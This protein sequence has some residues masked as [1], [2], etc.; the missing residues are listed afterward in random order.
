MTNKEEQ[1]VSK[2]ASSEVFAFS[3][4]E[5]RLTVSQSPAGYA[6]TTYCPF[7]GKGIDSGR[8][9]ANRISAVL[10]TKSK[11]RDHFGRCPMRNVQRP[12]LGV[13]AN[14]RAMR[15]PRRNA[16]VAR[17]RGWKKAEKVKLRCVSRTA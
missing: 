12:P 14:W 6:A 15:P 3:A 10:Q 2:A 11:F 5:C 16:T 7:C 8:S 17:R 13:N 1:G 4:V 9:D